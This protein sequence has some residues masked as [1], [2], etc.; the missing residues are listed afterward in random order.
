MLRISLVVKE[1]KDDKTS[2]D[3]KLEK[4]KNIEKATETEKTIS[5]GI[6]NAIN[7]ALKELQELK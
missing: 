6:Y 5:A 7:K 1:K 2:C 3:V 4:P